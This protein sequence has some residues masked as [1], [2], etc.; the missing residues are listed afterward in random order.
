MDFIQ[1]IICDGQLPVV[2]AF[3]LGIM[4]AVHPCPLATNIAAMGYIAR[5]TGHGK[6]VFVSGLYYTLGRIIA[7]SLLGAILYFV[8]KNGSDLLHIG[9]LSGQLG[10]KLLA[11]VL[12][13]IGLY[14]IFQ[15]FFHKEGEHCANV[16]A[17]AGRFHG[18]W[19]SMVLGLIL[20]LSFCPESAIVYFGVL[21]PLSAKTNGGVFLPVV[22]SI[23]TAIPTV[24]LAWTV[25]YGLS[26]VVFKER[27]IAVQ[28]WINMICALLFVAAGVYIMFN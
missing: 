28:R 12:I 9:E 25:S 16:G 23:A 1:T 3:L 15:R 24:L 10:E 17:H 5:D 19:G 11:P 27:M 8:Y 18:R 13:V 6:R 7:Y 14:F 20:A 4:V 22:F 21:M 2:T 26:S